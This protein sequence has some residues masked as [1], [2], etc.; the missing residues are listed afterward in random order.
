MNENPDMSG[1]KPFVKG[2]S[3]NPAGKPPGI[4]NR[5]T[6]IRELLEAAADG[7]IDKTNAD[8]VAAALLN[9]AKKG[10]ISAI[11]EILDSGYG[12]IVDRTEATHTV[13]Q[14]GRVVVGEGEKKKELTFDIGKAIGKPDG[15]TEQ[16]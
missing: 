12:K 15:A 6:L 16:D 1:L 10:D 9:Q 11:K 8:L 14:M 3:G 4:R 7:Q 13:L 2:Q 5:S